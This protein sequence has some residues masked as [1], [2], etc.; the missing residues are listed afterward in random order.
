MKK[1]IIFLL[2]STITIPVFAQVKKTKK[3]I[4]NT[5]HKEV[6]IKVCD[7]KLMGCANR[8]VIKNKE[9]LIDPITKS[10]NTKYLNVVSESREHNKLEQTLKYVT[11][12]TKKE[13]GH[14]PNPTAEF[15]VFK[16]T[17]IYVPEEK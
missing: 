16:L 17:D 2:I 14:F 11:G 1:I 8:L 10:A 6:T 15:E 9:Y 4:K 3:Q 5:T 7:E 12:Y 13:K